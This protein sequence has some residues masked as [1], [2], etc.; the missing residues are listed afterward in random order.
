MDATDVTILVVDDMVVDRLFIRRLVEKHDGWRVVLAADGVEALA[1]IAR[2]APAAV[3]TDL[4]MPNMD[5]LALVEQV[6]Q[7]FPRVPVVLM[8]GHGSE[9]IA[10]A[11][12][13]A[14]AVS[15][16]PKCNL[17]RDLFSTL[18]Q[19]LAASQTDDQRTRVLGALTERSSRYVIENDPVLVSPLVQVLREEMVAFGLCDATGATRA[20]IALEEAVLNA[21]Y[22]GNLGVNSDLKLAGDGSFERTAAERRSVAPYR[23]RRA[24][25]SSHVTPNGATFVVADEG[26]GFD[27]SSLPDPTDPANLERPSGRGILF[28]RTFMNDVHYNTAGNQVTLVKLRETVLQP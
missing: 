9:E 16:V 28:M 19:V 11:A 10:I 8:T 3:L 18:E 5:G 17:N 1:A 21:I 7:R 26:P 15:Y 20:G 24:S 6:R 13:R 22:H 12:L 25:V 27:V 4:Q 23:D 2:S 14:G